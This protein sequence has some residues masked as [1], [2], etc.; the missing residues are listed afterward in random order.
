M[1]I[2]HYV[3]QIESSRDPEA[4][5][6]L[7]GQV[8]DDAGLSESDKQYLTGTIGRYLADADREQQAGAEHDPV[9]APD[10]EA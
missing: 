1:D 10:E 5:E 4:L 6:R 3:T 2:S 9:D 7:R 8:L